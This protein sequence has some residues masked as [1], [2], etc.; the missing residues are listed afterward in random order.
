MWS[1]IFSQRYF[2]D[3]FDEP[4]EH[5]MVLV[6]PRETTYF[7]EQIPAFDIRYIEDC[8]RLKDYPNPNQYLYVLHKLYYNNYLHV[9]DY[10]FFMKHKH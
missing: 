6:K 7:H 10:K 5:S 8:F 9:F 4:N 3:V 1:Y 2:A